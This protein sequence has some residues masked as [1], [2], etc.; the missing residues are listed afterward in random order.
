MRLRA[1]TKKLLAKKHRT[2]TF[3]IANNALRFPASG[4]DN[5]Q[6][7]QLFNVTPPPVLPDSRS[8]NAVI[9]NA[10]REATLAAGVRE[11]IDYA[12]VSGLHLAQK[13]RFSR[14]LPDVSRS[15]VQKTFKRRSV[16]PSIK[17]KIQPAPLQIFKK[18]IELNKQRYN[19]ACNTVFFGQSMLLIERALVNRAATKRLRILKSEINQRVGPKKL[20]P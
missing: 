19:T 3:L 16:V 20:V 6:R 4:I 15:F 7:Q 10:S 13:C 5:A 14:F 17:S 11:L 12:T 8:L 1:V 9:S 18:I 2:K